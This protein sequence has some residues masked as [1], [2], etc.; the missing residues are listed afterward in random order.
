M[1]INTCISTIGKT[2]RAEVRMQEIMVDYVVQT[3]EKAIDSATLRG[4][5]PTTEDLIFLVRKVS[6]PS[7]HMVVVLLHKM[8]AAELLT[9]VTLDTT[10]TKH[11]QDRNLNWS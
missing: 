1:Q 7:M 3:L 8:L 9:P 5:K 11:R 4:G 2:T 6:C 10:Y